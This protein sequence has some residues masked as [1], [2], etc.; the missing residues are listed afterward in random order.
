MGTLSQQGSFT[1]TSSPSNEY[2]DNRFVDEQKFAPDTTDLVEPIP[3]YARPDD[4]TFSHTEVNASTFINRT[5]YDPN[6]Y[7]DAYGSLMM[8][9]GGTPIRVTYYHQIFADNSERTAFGDADLVEDNIHSDFERI[10]N[11]EFRTDSPMS[12]S[13]D[14]DKAESTFSGEGIVYPGF[15]PQ[16]GDLFTYNIIDATGLFIITGFEPL[17]IRQ[18]SYHKISFTL[19]Q[20]LDATT[21]ATLTKRCKADLVF[22]TQK[23]LSG[24]LTLLKK[25]AYIALEKLCALRITLAKT[26]MSKFFDRNIDSIVRPDNI[27]DP[28]IVQYILKKISAFDVRVSPMQLVKIYDYDTTIWSQFTD[29][30]TNTLSDFNIGMKI[31]R[32]IDGVFTTQLNG[33]TNRDYLSASYDTTT[34]LDDMT[35]IKPYVFSDNFFNHDTGNMNKMEQLV[36]SYM[37]CGKVDPFDTVELVTNYRLLSL[38]DL[39]YRGAVYLHLIDTAIASIT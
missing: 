9:A 32:K 13:W 12:F 7:P 8:Y 34:E 6:R 18:G 11:F 16:V 30:K 14:S 24:N 19:L 4:T 27:Y 21:L 33:L 35:V 3:Q 28:Y 1:E 38:D 25:D 10:I 15:E 17:S 22:D 2:T 20:R 39:F 31:R 36:Y 26:Y 37:A 5:S 29:V 23:Y